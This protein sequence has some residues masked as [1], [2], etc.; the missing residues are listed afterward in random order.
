MNRKS[1]V[2]VSSDVFLADRI[3][4]FPLYSHPSAGAMKMVCA[5][6]DVLE[7]KTLQ[8]WTQRG[9]IVLYVDT[10]DH[11]LYQRYAETALNELLACT[12]LPGKR[13]AEIYYKTTRELVHE[14]C[15]SNNL[16]DLV[17][18]HRN[19]FANN[20]ASL[21]CTDE[22]TRDGILVMLCHDYYTY[23]HMINVSVMV[24]ALAYRL[25]ITDRRRL[26]EV[27]GGGL[28]HDIGKMRIN[29][30]VLNKTDGLTPGDWEE[31]KL[32]PVRGLEY[33]AQRPDSKR[34]ELLMV[35]QHH[36]KLD[37]SGYPTGLMGDEISAEAQMT[38][39]VDI[40]DALTCKRPYRE[41][42]SHEE[43]MSVLND[44][45]GSKLSVEL[46]EAWQKTIERVRKQ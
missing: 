38:A 34:C 4:P 3:V 37:G 23:T 16:D 6:S 18:E 29:P 43:A 25:S 32:H 21:I 12:D 7:A 26:G 30:N 19:N 1:Y 28:L 42:L 5:A 41:A 44:Q 15:T 10:A 14:A 36:E 11:R 9:G 31:I 27:A 2:P 45:A 8:T 17:G 20:L 22:A 33:L 46:V 24:S 40:Y 39:V 13:K 35:H